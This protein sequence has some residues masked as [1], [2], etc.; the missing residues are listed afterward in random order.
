MVSFPR[1]DPGI[2]WFLA[3]AA[4]RYRIRPEAWR[5]W[6]RH[7]RISHLLTEVVDAIEV[8]P[9]KDLQVVR[10]HRPPAVVHV[11]TATVFGLRFRVHGIRDGRG[12]WVEVWRVI[13][14]ELGA[15]SR[16][17]DPTGDPP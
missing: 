10:I 9:E 6:D 12:L 11:V 16:I 13:P 5:A 7:P 4:P 3:E 1:P 14:L 17:P 15:G 8:L 2:A